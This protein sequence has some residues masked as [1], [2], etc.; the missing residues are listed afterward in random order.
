MLWSWRTERMSISSSTLGSSGD[1]STISL[2][3]AVIVVDVVVVVIVV[4][5]HIIMRA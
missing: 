5:E 4:A 3:C 2:S 1:S